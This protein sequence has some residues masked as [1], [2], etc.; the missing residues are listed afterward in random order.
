[1]QVSATTPSSVLFFVD[2]LILQMRSLFSEWDKRA[3]N[4]RKNWRFDDPK[5][6]FSPVFPVIL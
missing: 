3:E 1:V 5:T 6:N 2:S 4:A